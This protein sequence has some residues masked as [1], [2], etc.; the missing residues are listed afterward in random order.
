MMF[1]NRIPWLTHFKSQRETKLCLCGAHLRN[2]GQVREIPSPHPQGQ[3]VFVC[4]NCAE[5]MPKQ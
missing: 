4:E 1:P 3:R 5:R 2:F